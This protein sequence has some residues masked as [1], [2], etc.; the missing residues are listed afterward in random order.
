LISDFE[1]LFDF[2]TAKNSKWVRNWRGDQ[3][4][5]SQIQVA[6]PNW[7]TLQYILSIFSLFFPSTKS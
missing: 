7:S 5:W 1:N 3:L 4:N 6:N 2:G